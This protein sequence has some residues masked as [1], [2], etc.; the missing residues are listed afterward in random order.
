MGQTSS[1]VSMPALALI[2]ADRRIVQSTETFRRSYEA[3]EALYEDS[4]EL[5]LVLT[6]QVDAAVV[7]VGEVSV[8]IEAVTD[9]SGA[10]QAMLSVSGEQGSAA[11]AAPARI[12][13]DSLEDS[14]AI[15][16]VKDLDGRYLYVNRRYRRELD[17]TEDRLRGRSDAELPPR[18][19]VDGPRQ[20]YADDGLEEPLE[21]EY[22]VPPF[23]GRPP[24]V[25]VRFVLRD[26]DG[27]PVGICGVAAP[28]EEAHVA[29]EEAVRLRQLERWKRLDPE[30]VRAEL[31]EQWQV[32]TTRG[33]T[34]LVEAEAAH[35]RP[36]AELGRPDLEEAP[37]PHPLEEGPQPVAQQ[38]PPQPTAHEEPPQP[39]ALEEAAQPTA[40]EEAPQ[41]TALQ[42]APQLTALEAPPQPVMLEAPPQPARSP[43]HQE[44]VPAEQPWGGAP[45]A[46]S[47]PVIQPDPVASATQLA[48]TDLALAREWAER[49]QQLQGDLEQVHA[50]VRQAEAE[51]Q[52]SLAAGQ[53]AS[54]EVQR[55]RGELEQTREELERARSEARAARSEAGAVRAELVAVRDAHRAQTEALRGP[56]TIALRLSEDLERA[57]A[58]ERERG[59]EL[60]RTLARVRARLG[61]LESALDHDRAG[62][63]PS[64]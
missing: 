37:Q 57:L 38:E 28:V 56:S 6:G 48:Q 13:R 54:E 22:M 59:D 55:L 3:A 45:A 60:A 30:D 42:E 33:Q 25:A 5:E 19:T 64:F 32:Q 58:A 21:L 51:L 31:L 47:S 62:H 4:P 14:P 27:E 18:D 16:W 52:Q 44:S 7:S 53:R 36:G 17:T 10:R 40:L 50:R 29:R 8:E 1:E 34:Q 63:P 43:E 49:A 2:G 24:L 9:T 41:L 39:T 23:E 26:A 61:D 35:A 11:A 12:P 15:V 46:T 20:R